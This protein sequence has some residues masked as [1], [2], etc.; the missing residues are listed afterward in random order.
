MA[1]WQPIET[2]PKDGTWIHV[3]R[4]IHQGIAWWNSHSGHWTVG[5]LIYFARPTHWMPLPDPPPSI[6]G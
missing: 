3:A 4:D 1:D 6:R 2:A 5:P